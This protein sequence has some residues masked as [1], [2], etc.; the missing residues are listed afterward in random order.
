MIK[1]KYNQHKEII[2]NFFWRSLQI[3]GKQGITFLIFIL[4]AKLL[5]PYEFGIYNYVLAIILFL[6]VFADFGMSTATSKYVTEYN[7]TDKEKLKSVLF[8]SGIIILGLTF[9]VSSVVLLFGKFYLG[10]KYIYVLYLL[11]LIFLIPIT[12]LYAGI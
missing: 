2:H 6:I 12:P 1:N 9:I 8:N 10:E 11:P 5:I 4:C 7:I 3:F